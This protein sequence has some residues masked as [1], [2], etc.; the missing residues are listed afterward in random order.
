MLCFN[1]LTGEYNT[2]KKFI[3]WEY[4]FKVNLIHECLLNKNV[5]IKYF[6]IGSKR[7]KFHSEF[8]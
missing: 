2:E 1:K 6:I 3:L 4:I 7:V 8:L 5:K